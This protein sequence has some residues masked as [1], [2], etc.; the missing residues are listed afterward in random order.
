MSAYIKR[1]IVTELPTTLEVGQ[2]VYYQDANGNLTLWV[3]HEDGSAWPSVGYKEYVAIWSQVGT[4]A[5]IAVVKSNTIGIVSLSRPDMGIS[6]AT[7]QGIDIIP[8]G[9]ANGVNDDSVIAYFCNGSTSA[10]DARLDV[11]S[12]TEADDNT[13]SVFIRIY[14]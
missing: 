7:F 11:R 2:E 9:F 6:R 10:G 1:T 4:N 14:P 13:I 12:S 8:I 3:G 5:P